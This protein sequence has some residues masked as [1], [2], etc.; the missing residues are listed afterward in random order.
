MTTEVTADP[1]GLPAG[2]YSGTIEATFSNGDSL[3]VDVVLIVTPPPTS[4]ERLS[5]LPPAQLEGCTPGEMVLIAETIG[6]GARVPISFP[7][8]LVVSL[9]DSCGEFVDDATVVG[10][11]EGTSIPMQALGNGTYSGTW[12]PQQ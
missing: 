4:P 1:T 3:D 9:I 6:N 8:I 12:V 7:R 5:A 11:T 2:V 10:S